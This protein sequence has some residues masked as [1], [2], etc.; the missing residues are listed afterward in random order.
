MIFEIQKYIMSNPIVLSNHIFI[1]LWFYLRDDIRNCVLS[2]RCRNI[3][4]SQDTKLLLHIS[5]LL[6]CKSLSLCHFPFFAV[7]LRISS[8]KLYLS[9]EWSFY[10]IHNWLGLKLAIFFYSF[11]SLLKATIFCNWFSYCRCRFFI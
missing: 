5:S 8:A 3:M 2:R 10:I 7:P 4:S 1:T 11:V 6:Y 9:G